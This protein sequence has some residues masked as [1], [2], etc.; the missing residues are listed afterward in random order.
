VT[1]E[2]CDRLYVIAFGN[3]IA[4]GMPA[5]IQENEAVIEAYLGSSHVAA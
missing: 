3:K 1:M 4:E 5:Q 2:V